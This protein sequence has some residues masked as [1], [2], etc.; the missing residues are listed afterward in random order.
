MALRLVVGSNAMVAVN[1][2]RC[3][4]VPV[5]SRDNVALCDAP[6]LAVL[7]LM[8]YETLFDVES[9]TLGVD[10][11]DGVMERVVVELS[12]RVPSVAEAIVVKETVS[13]AVGSKLRDMLV[14]EVCVV[15]LLLRGFSSDRVS[16]CD[17]RP[18]DSDVL[19]VP[20]ASR[21]WECDTAEALFG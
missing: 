4:R 1:V 15:V 18:K 7:P 20:D 3:E 8:L 13:L 2:S 5:V 17:L 19:S 10:D 14:S 12:V 11:A 16:E 21:L 6:L 9:F